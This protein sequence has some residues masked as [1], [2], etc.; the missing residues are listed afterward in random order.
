MGF[1]FERLD[2]C[3]IGWGGIVCYSMKRWEGSVEVVVGRIED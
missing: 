3:W 2:S 1:D